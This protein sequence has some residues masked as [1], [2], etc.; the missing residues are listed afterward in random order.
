MDI[1]PNI[2]AIFGNNGETDSNQHEKQGKRVQNLSVVNVEEP[3]IERQNDGH[4]T[5][6]KSPLTSLSE[7]QVAS[8]RLLG[9]CNDFEDDN[10][11]VIVD[12][13]ENEPSR[14]SEPSLFVQMATNR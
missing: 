9:D 4:G 6:E 2:G 10:N 8:E 5:T 7:R 12:T 13:I 3:R 11:G 14:D 1:K